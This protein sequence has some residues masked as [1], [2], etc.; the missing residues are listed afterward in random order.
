MNRLLIILYI[1]VLD[2]ELNLIVQMNYGI[3]FL[4]RKMAKLMVIRIMAQSQLA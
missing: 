3:I 1:G 2:V 4:M